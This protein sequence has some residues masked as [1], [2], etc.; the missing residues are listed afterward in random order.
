MTNRGKGVRSMRGEGL[1]TISFSS[2]KGGVGKS[3]LV[4]NL[5]LILAKQ[6][7]RVPLMDGDM[8][9]ANIYI[10]LGLAPRYTLRHVLTG[11]KELEEII[12]TGPA[13]LQII[14]AAS[15]V[16][17]LA[18]LGEPERQALIQRLGRLEDLADVLLVD[19]G[20]G[21]S[22]TVLSLLLACQEAV[23]VTTPEPTAIT[24]AYALAKVVARRR[25]THPLR[26]VVNMVEGATQA[27]EVYRNI[28]RVLQRFVRCRLDFA[29]HVV[30]DPLVGKAVQEQKP[31][32]IYY[33]YAKATRCITALAGTLLAGAPGG[34]QWGEFWGK[35]AQSAAQG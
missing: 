5:G 23:V 27:E 29:G 21:I 11:E 25:A 31:L 24:D 4:V 14:P 7:Y 8:G 16:E 19:T 32:S 30:W 17:A 33:P 28:Q 3:S 6:G 12:L 15:G 9:L 18:N 10:L 34:E 26:L 1:R 2:G 35:M 22:A 20:A 13:G